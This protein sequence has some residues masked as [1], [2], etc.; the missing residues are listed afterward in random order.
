MKSR[1][2]L[3]AI[4]MLAMTISV[5]SACQPQEEQEEAKV[6]R[7]GFIGPLTGNVKTFGES[8]RNGF[9]MAIEE[10]N[11]AVGDYE[12]KYFIED[13]RNDPTEAVNVAD[14][15]ISQNKVHVII[16]SVTSSATIPVTEVA[17]NNKVVQVTQYGYSRNRN[18]R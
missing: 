7:I 1:K 9:L 6:V 10:S 12:I 5:L 4:L 18:C 8:T 3:V 11:G 13:D 17:N 14:K 16:G 2:L 15:L